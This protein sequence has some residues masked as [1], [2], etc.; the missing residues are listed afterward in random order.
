[1]SDPRQSTPAIS[2]S[3]LITE[4]EAAALLAVTPRGLASLRKKR[5]IP[6]IRLGKLVRYRVSDLDAALERLTV[7][8]KK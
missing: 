4:A 3:S 7:E 6:H 2:R 5:L 1:M 8:A